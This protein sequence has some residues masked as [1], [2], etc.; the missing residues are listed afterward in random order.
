[1]YPL[2]P[3]PTNGEVSGVLAL[4]LPSVPHSLS[5]RSS[6]PA[7]AAVTHSYSRPVPPALPQLCPGLDS[8]TPHHACSSSRPHPQHP[9]RPNPSAVLTQLTAG[10]CPFVLLRA[11]FGVTNATAACSLAPLSLASHSDAAHH[12]RHLSRFPEMQI[13]SPLSFQAHTPQP[14]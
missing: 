8:C 6:T 7:C 4:V 12:T 13:G 10:S 1:M 9:S 5:R 2:P 3:S 14:G 11:W